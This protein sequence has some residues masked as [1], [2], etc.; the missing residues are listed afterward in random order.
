MKNLK[1]GAATISKG[2][3]KL[4]TMSPKLMKM[5]Q[6]NPYINLPMCLLTQEFIKV[7]NGTTPLTT[8]LG[9]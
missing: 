1:S 9:A 5:M 2:M 4:K 7:S 8:S 3:I 6:T